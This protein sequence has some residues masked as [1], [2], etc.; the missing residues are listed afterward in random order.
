MSIDIL[1]NEEYNYGVI[2]YSSIN[3]GDEIQSVASS[4]F[5]PDEILNVHRERISKFKAPDSKKVKVIMNAWWMWEP[6]NFPPPS[7][8]DPLLI[9]MHIQGNILNNFLSDKTKQYLIEHG[10]VGCRDKGSSDYLNKN[11]VPAY[12]SGC[13]TLTLQRNNKI[14]RKNHIL[15]VDCP[16]DVVEEIK[17]R[18][19]RPVYSISRLISPYF[20]RE[21]RVKIAKLMLKSYQEAFCVVSPCLHVVLPCLALQTPVLRLIK[22]NTEKTTDYRFFGFE[23]YFHQVCSTDFINNKTVYNFN[24][25]PKNPN[26]YLKTRNELIKKCE[27]FTG[28]NR[29]ESLIPNDDNDLLNMLSM[30]SWTWKKKHRILKFVE[31]EDMEKAIDSL[32]KGITRQ[33]LSY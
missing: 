1:K 28:I 17:T 3:I 2:S 4:R 33:D 26:L 8:I 18:T 20:T 16:D 31:I 11:G 22:G 13:L 10:P 23:G 19:N 5:L 15:C 32:K 30:S 25:P 21:D 14:K 6:V 9:S 12:F 7:V 24:R 27:E 29:E